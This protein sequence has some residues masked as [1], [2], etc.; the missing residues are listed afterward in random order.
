MEPF[1]QKLRISRFQQESTKLS[2]D[3]FKCRALCDSFSLMER[4]WG[5]AKSPGCS[6]AQ[7]WQECEDILKKMVFRV[8]K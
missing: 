2:T 7:E 4:V 3:S 6:Q 1:V 5:W 8:A